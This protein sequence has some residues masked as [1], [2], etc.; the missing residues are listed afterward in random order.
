MS[1]IISYR[2]YSA[3]NYSKI[4]FEGNGI[5]L[6][7]LRSEIISQKKLIAKDFDLLFYDSQTNEQLL[8]D[9][10]LVYRN[11]EIVVKRVPLWMSKNNHIKYD[12]ENQKKNDKNIQRNQFLGSI[13]KQPPLNY[14]C[15][16]CGQKGHFIQ[17]CPTNEDKTF[18]ILRLRKPTGIPKAFLKP[19]K[20]DEIKSENAMLVTEEGSCVRAEPQIQEWQKKKNRDDKHIDGKKRKKYNYPSALCCSECESLVVNPVITN[21]NHIFCMSCVNTESYCVICKKLI[22]TVTIDESVKD[23]VNEYSK[24]E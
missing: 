1:S 21:C 4:N 22:T 5:P 7:E 8:D 14:I 23:K 20:K 3:K 17:H 18:D 13:Y 24:T 16:R 15:F 19:V 11:S 9:Y 12:V 6:W 10:Q 2:F